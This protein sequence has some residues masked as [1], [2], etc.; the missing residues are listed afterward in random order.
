MKPIICKDTQ[1]EFDNYK[2]YLKSEHWKLF[3]M[4]YWLNNRDKFFCSEC[5]KDGLSVSLG[6]HHLHYSTLGKEAFGDVIPLCNRCHKKKHLPKKSTKSSKKKPKQP[7]RTPTPPD[8][9]KFLNSPISNSLEKKLVKLLR[10]EFRQYF[11]CRRIKEDNNCID[12]K[13]NGILGKINP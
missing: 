11:R 7:L 3:R 12:Q 6:L 8:L 9:T 1:E 2:D 4:R 10:K 13:I 5:Q